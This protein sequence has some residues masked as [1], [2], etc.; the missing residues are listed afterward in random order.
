MGRWPVVG[1]EW[2]VDLLAHALE[3]QRLRHAYLFT[4][5][6]QV[7]KHTLATAFASVMLCERGP[8]A[9][10]CGECRSCRLVVLGRHPD[11]QLISAE[12]N[13]Q[14]DQVRN[15]QADAALSPVE[16]PRKVFI[17]R[18]I[19]RATA[20]AAN[21]LLKTL[22]EPPP[23]VVL[24]CTSVR[25]DQLLPTILSRCQ[26]MALRPLPE[27]QVISA[28]VERWNVPEEQAE[29]LARLS[30]GKLGWAV[31]AH[32]D[33]ALWQERI[34]RLDDLLAL[35]EQGYVAR[36]AYAEFLAK[37][38][39]TA[40]RTLSL[41]AGWWRDLLLV[42]KG[43][44]AGILNLDRRAQLGQ[45]AALFRP[46]SVERA[47]DDTVRTVRRLHANVNVRLALEVL[48]LRIPRSAVA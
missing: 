30:G 37:Q 14:I 6:A 32:S 16:G 4:G 13:I 7:G 19:E 12:R 46:E 2:A 45:Q 21:A 3:Q 26:I 42:Q 11:V 47:L 36:L 20:P 33:P 1:H 27:S 48:A 17:L 25:R 44:P 31:T 41:W 8:A 15:V 43:A 18:E 40:V 23:H 38:F 34:R 22:E 10:P 35:T 39:D 28:L 29:L 9:A 24:I 5:P